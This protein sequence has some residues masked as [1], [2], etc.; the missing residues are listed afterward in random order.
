MEHKWSRVL[1]SAPEIWCSKVQMKYS[2]MRNKFAPNTPILASQSKPKHWIFL[3]IEWVKDPCMHETHTLC[4][5]DDAHSPVQI[6][7]ESTKMKAFIKCRPSHSVLCFF[8]RFTRDW[9]GSCA[10]SRLNWYYMHFWFTGLRP[11]QPSR[12]P[13]QPSW[14]PVKKKIREKY[15]TLNHRQNQRVK[16][17]A[18]TL[19]PFELILE[20]DCCAKRNACSI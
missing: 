4:F 14:Q 15:Q 3:S 12:R 13:L 1:K 7:N 5:K 19:W 9:W 2:R 8:N 11:W 16:V 10:F 6:R 17:S 20:D 18:L